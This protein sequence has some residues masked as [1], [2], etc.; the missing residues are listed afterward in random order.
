[1]FGESLGHGQDLA[2]YIDAL[3]RAASAFRRSARANFAESAR[4]GSEPSDQAPPILPQCLVLPSISHA[5]SAN[6]MPW[7]PREGTGLAWTLTTSEYDKPC[8]QCTARLNLIEI[9]VS[10]AR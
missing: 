4:Q 5:S 9:T 8:A 7:N 6:V 10:V 3:S 1:M 2:I